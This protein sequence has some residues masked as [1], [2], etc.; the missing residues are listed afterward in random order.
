[1]TMPM[2]SRKAAQFADRLTMPRVSGVVSF[3][4][5]KQARN[6]QGAPYHDANLSRFGMT[7]RRG[8]IP[9]L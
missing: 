8:R 4:G 7:W 6:G 9:V 1:M 3:D 2:S 5:A